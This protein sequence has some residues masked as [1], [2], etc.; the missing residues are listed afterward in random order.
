MNV[1]NLIMWIIIVLL[2]VGLFN[3]FQDPNNI[4][5]EKNTLAF[6]N[7]LNEVDAGRVVEVQIQGNN[8]SGVLADGNTFKTYSPNYPELVDKL[9]SKGV[10]IIASPQEDKMPSLLGILLSW[11]PMLLLIG[12]W[13]FFMRQMQGGKGGAMGFGRSKAKLLNE[14]QGKVTFNDVAGVEEAKEEVEEIVEFLKDPK[15]FSRLGGKIPKGAL[16]I[17]PPGTGKTTKLLKRKGTINGVVQKGRQVGKKIGFPTCNI[18]IKDYVLAKPG[19]YAVR[20][21]VPNNYKYLKGIANLG[22]RPTFNQ[23]KILLEVHL[24]NYSGNL[25]NKLLSVEFIKFIREEKKFKNVNQLKSQ[26]KKDLNIA[27][28][29]K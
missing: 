5:S 11:F 14:A 19:V 6:S 3:M 22:Y 26:I 12:V 17:G 1:K 21:L 9:S 18:D 29:T 8:I 15:K 23:K 16:L 7:F 4:N 2:S 25:Y 20:V 28:K 24:F 10:S 27:K 13:I